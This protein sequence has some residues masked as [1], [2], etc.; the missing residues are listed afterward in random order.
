[1]L[2]VNRAS[3]FVIPAPPVTVRLAHACCLTAR[4]YNAWA[5]QR[6]AYLLQLLNGYLI[7]RL[8]VDGCI[9]PAAQR[10]CFLLAARRLYFHPAAQRPSVSTRLL[11]GDMFVRLLN[12]YVILRLLLNGYIIPAAA[13]GLLFV[14][15]RMPNEYISCSSAAQSMATYSF[16]Y[17]TAI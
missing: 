16:T 4:A 15:L 14:F 8:L 10:I 9:P 1:M 6:L 5:A 11:D 12:D 2:D 3:F 13:Q 17:S 7:L